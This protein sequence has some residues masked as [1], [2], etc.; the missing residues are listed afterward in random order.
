[1]KRYK[2]SQTYSENVCRMPTMRWSLAISKRCAFRCGPGRIAQMKITDLTVLT[3]YDQETIRNNGQTSYLRLKTFVK[4]HIDR[5][6]RTRNFRIRRK[7]VERGAV[8]RVKKGKKVNVERKVGECFDRHMDNVQKE[9]L[10]VSVMTDQHKETCPMISDE[11][12]D[13]PLPYQDSKIKTHDK[14]EIFSRTSSDRDESSSRQKKRNSV[15]L[16]KLTIPVM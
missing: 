12:N 2:D 16:Q 14:G 7:V 1:M 8:P 3:L 9:T 5:M 10:V 4:L 13:R 15:S 6:M 11:D